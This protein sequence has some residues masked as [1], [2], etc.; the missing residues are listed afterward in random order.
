[1]IG[2]DAPCTREF[3]VVVTRERNIT[4]HAPR[5]K[6]PIDRT[7]TERHEKGTNPMQ[8]LLVTTE[9]LAEHLDD[10]QVCLLDCRF[11]VGHDFRDDY[12][13]GHIPGARYL[14]WSRELAD[15]EH[16][17]DGMIAPPAVV[18][19]TLRRYGI[20]DDTTI[21]CYD[22]EGGHFASRV[23]LVLERYGRGSQVRIV[24]GGWTAW[25]QEGRP[26]TVATPADATPGNFTLDPATARPE[27]IADWQQVLAAA[28][29]E[30][31]EADT[32]LLD[33]RRMS[34]FTGEEVR[35][36]RGGRVPNAVWSFWQDYVRWDDDRRF[37]STEEITATLANVGVTQDTPVITYCQGAVRAAHTVIALERAGFTNVRV[38]DGSWAEWGNRDDLPIVTGPADS[39]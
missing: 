36:A 1:M 39:V 6:H 24:D 35:A 15:L 4:E 3:I 30:G 10:P 18:E 16:T 20:N 34:E 17:V 27:L 21:V 32:V 22:Q 33:V 37:R 9:W 11:G 29:G 8:D 14:A 7:H 12:A 28:Q 38:Y 31:S 25:L 2:S 23:W 5:S 26:T 13:A 19:A